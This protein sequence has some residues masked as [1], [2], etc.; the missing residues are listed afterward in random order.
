M[1][2]KGCTC[3]NTFEIPYSESEVEAICITYKQGDKTLFDKKLNDC[4]FSEGAVTVHLNQEDTLKFDS[5]KVI[6]I[7]LKVKLVG[8]MVTKSN[9]VETITDELLCCEVI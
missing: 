5:Q 7:Q 6:K 9:I 8:D 4:T 2:P 3:R 1:I